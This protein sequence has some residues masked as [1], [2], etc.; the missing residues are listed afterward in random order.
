MGHQLVDGWD[1]IGAAGASPSTQR[2][3]LPSLA[4]SPREQLFAW[5]LLACFPMRPSLS[6]SKILTF[7]KLAS[8]PSNFDGECELKKQKLCFDDR[9]ET[10]SWLAQTAACRCDRKR[11]KVCALQ[12]R[13]SASFVVY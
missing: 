7:E 2:D 9:R 11:R 3:S 5:T 8:L 13:T 12:R 6:S 1:H 4:A 10:T